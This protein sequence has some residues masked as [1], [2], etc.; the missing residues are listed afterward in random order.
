M[1]IALLQDSQEDEHSCFSDNTH[2]DIFLNALGV[3]NAFTGEYQRIDGSVLSGSGIDD[4]L[5]S[6]GEVA[7]ENQ[8]GAALEETMIGLSVI[9][10]EAKTG[11]PF[12][13][14]IQ[15]AAAKLV[16]A[17]GIGKLAAQTEAIEDVIQA[18]GLTTGD[19]RQDTEEE[20]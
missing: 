7:L 5:L 20:I 4:L 9:D 19:L 2:R 6:V 15:D 3:Q 13:N 16:I 8:L 14:Q 10:Q 17:A 1:N 11:V 12:D 18:L